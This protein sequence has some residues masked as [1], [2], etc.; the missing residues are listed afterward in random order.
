M[1]ETMDI[2]FVGLEYFQD[3]VF[4][5]IYGRDIEIKRLIRGKE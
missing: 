3:E 1:K 4:K 2:L 5:I